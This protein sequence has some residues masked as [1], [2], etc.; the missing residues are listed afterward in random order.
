VLVPSLGSLVLGLA[1]VEGRLEAAEAHRLA[2]LDETFQE[3]LWGTDA[4]AAARRKR[5][6]RELALAERLVALS[7]G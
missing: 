4:E 6:G 7:R 1:V 5:I 2:T 3:S